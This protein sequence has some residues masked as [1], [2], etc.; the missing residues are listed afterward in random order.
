MES[1]HIPG[2]K[3]VYK[4]LHWQAPPY[5]AP[6]DSVAVQAAAKVPSFFQFLNFFYFFFLKLELGY[7]AP[8]D[9]VAVQTAAKVPLSKSF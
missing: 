2:T 9:S 1:V 7:L 8:R 4:P 3:L 5:L 6:R